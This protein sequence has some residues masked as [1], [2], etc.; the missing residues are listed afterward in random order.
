MTV[1]ISFGGKQVGQQYSTRMRAISKRHRKAIDAAV[2]DVRDEALVAARADIAGAGNFGSRWTK[3]LKA[4]IEDEG[5]NVT[6]G[7]THDV[8][9]FSV[10]QTGRLIK[11]KPLLAIPLSHADDA[12]GVLARNFPG[13]LFR[14]DRKA[15]G[16]PLLL[17][18]KTGEPKYFLKKQVYIPKKFRVKEIIRETAQK[19]K[20]FVLQRLKGST[21]G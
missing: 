2:R 6:I 20:N 14:V 16:A 1:K 13:G 9:Y 12:Q 18:R 11:G 4:G 15:G 5:D 19:F 3:G 7:F 8:P 17:S 10:F 21:N